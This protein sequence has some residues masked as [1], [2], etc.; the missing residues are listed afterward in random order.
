MASGRI[1]PKVGI[2]FSQTDRFSG[3]SLNLANYFCGL[4]SASGYSE[5]F[6]IGFE[7]DGMPGEVCPRRVKYITRGTNTPKEV[8]VS[9]SGVY[10]D[11]SPWLNPF[12]TPYCIARYRMSHLHISMHYK[13]AT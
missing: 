5:I 10:A 3:E 12:V 2:V 11:G 6:M 13:T 4:L 1:K 9:C 8:P 7:S